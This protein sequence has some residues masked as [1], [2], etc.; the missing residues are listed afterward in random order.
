LLTVITVGALTV[1][2]MVLYLMFNSEL[3]RSKMEKECTPLL[4]PA[5]EE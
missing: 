5:D 4:E 2:G 1:T 3:K